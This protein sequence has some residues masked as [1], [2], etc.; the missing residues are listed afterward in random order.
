MRAK[1]PVNARNLN[2]NVTKIPVQS[3]SKNNKILR[4]SW[5]FGQGKVVNPFWFIYEIFISEKVR[6]IN[7]EKFFN[8]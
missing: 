2:N 3:V 4:K 7:Y 6:L 5:E 8:V 1:K